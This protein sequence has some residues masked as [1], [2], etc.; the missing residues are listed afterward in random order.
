MN[1]IRRER[2]RSA[3]TA[4]QFSESLG[5]TTEQLTGYESGEAAPGLRTLALLKSHIFV[6]MRPAEPSS[7]GDY[8]RELAVILEAVLRELVK[9]ARRKET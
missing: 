9:V 4:E 8:S 3:A 6:S 2:T 5:I 1:V 7:F